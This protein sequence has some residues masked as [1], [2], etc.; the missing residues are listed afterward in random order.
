MLKGTNFTALQQ[1]R[2]FQSYIIQVPFVCSLRDLMDQKKVNFFPLRFRI[3]LPSLHGS[4]VS[5]NA[6]QAFLFNEHL[7]T[8]GSGHCC[9]SPFLYSV[10]SLLPS[11]LL[12]ERGYRPCAWAEEHGDNFR[13]PSSP[14]YTLCTWDS[15]GR[16]PS[17][18]KPHLKPPFDMDDLIIGAYSDAFGHKAE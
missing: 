7:H 3:F 11:L 5:L 15:T 16:A 2:P 8:S 9:F 6:E 12:S 17:L 14:S 4:V 1:P 10:T 18:I 13:R